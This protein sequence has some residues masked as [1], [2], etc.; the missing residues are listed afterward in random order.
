MCALADIDLSQYRGPRL[1]VMA[2]RR[3]PDAIVASYEGACRLLAVLIREDADLRNLILERFNGAPTIAAFSVAAETLQR[4]HLAHRAERVAAS[5]RAAEFAARG[6]KVCSKCGA[7]KRLEEF[8][9]LARNADGRR[10]ECR[11]CHNAEERNRYAARKGERG[12][13]PCISRHGS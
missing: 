5:R 6:T 3:D 1:V 11:A 13:R 9:R 4:A 12:G 7:E 8:S 2:G 10:P